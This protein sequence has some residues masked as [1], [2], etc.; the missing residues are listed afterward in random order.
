[1][2]ANVIWSCK[3]LKTGK[4]KKIFEAFQ[5]WEEASTEPVVPLESRG[6]QKGKG[7]FFQT[8]ISPLKKRRFDWI[9][10]S[11]D[12][13]HHDEYF[14]CKNFAPFTFSFLKIKRNFGVTNLVIWTHSVPAANWIAAVMLVKISS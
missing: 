14:G 12:S 8:Q 10:T 4:K 3:H 5:W 13:S 7:V 11:F 1:M 9:Y 2:K 6:K